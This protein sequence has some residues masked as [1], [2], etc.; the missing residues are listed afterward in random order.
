MNMNKLLF[1]S[2]FLCVTA[3][4]FTSCKNEEDDLFSQSAAERLD[5][6]KTQYTAQMVDNAPNGWVFQYFPNE[7]TSTKRSYGYVLLMKFFGDHRVAMAMS[8]R[9]SQTGAYATD[10]S[11][12]EVITDNGP[13]LSFNSYNECLHAFSNPFLETPTISYQTE[14]TFESG[15]GIGGDYEFVIVDAPKEGK[16]ITLKG[17]KRATYS[18]MLALPEAVDSK[19]YFD[20]LTQL[21]SDFFPK[22][23]NTPC[24]LIQ[25]GQTYVVDSMSTGLPVI[26]PEGG[27]ATDDGKRIPFVMAKVGDKYNVRFRDPINFSKDTNNKNASQ[28]FIYNPTDDTFESVS[29][30]GGKLMPIQPIPFY[31]KRLK[32]IAYSI[33]Y[34]NTASMSENLSTLMNNFRQQQNGFSSIDLKETDGTMLLTVHYTRYIN[35]GYRPAEASF[36]YHVTYNAEDNT[37]TLVLDGP[38]DTIASTL[39]TNNSSL[40]PL[41]QAFEQTFKVSGHVT[42]FSLR[43]MKMVSTTD[44][45]MWLIL[46]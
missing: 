25:E 5:S 6:Y 41:L 13:V 18:R 24:R 40:Q 21:N 1:A 14:A 32:N 42:N 34:D 31:Q 44:S 30:N 35:R 29:D 3:M 7:E 45:N 26:Y 2:A 37:M 46:N 43:R 28:E 15:E 20:E 33:R 12:W 22:S 8:N 16:Y 11:L 17:K 39:L 19:Q 9:Y 10:T 23:F 27:N 38:M 36:K 4:L